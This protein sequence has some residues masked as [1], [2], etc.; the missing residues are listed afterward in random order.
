MNL[1]GQARGTVTGVIVS[2]RT[3]KALSSIRTILTMLTTG[4]FMG[5]TKSEVAEDA[6]MVTELVCENESAF[7]QTH[8]PNEGLVCAFH[9]KGTTSNLR[10]CFLKMHQSTH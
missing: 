10:V 8:P 9:I 4:I 3:V 2:F 7:N 6:L 1:L 5:E